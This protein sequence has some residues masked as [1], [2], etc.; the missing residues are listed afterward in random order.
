M[1]PFCPKQLKFAV[2][3]IFTAYFLY[4]LYGPETEKLGISE[5]IF[6]IFRF[7]CKYVTAVPQLL[8]NL[9]YSACATF[10]LEMSLVVKEITM[11][12]P[13]YLMRN[14]FVLTSSSY[15]LYIT[16]YRGTD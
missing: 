13:I 6:K 2:A 8:A 12:H 9:S 14:F 5:F 3:N 15:L 11:L 10:S 1:S 4:L 7:Y 16:D